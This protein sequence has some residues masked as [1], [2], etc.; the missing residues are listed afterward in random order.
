MSLSFKYTAFRRFCPKFAVISINTSV[1]SIIICSKSPK[2]AGKLKQNIE[3][4]VGIPFECIFIDNSTCNYSIFSAYNEGIRRSQYPYL[5]FLHEDVA[6]QT[7]DWGKNLCSHLMN[8]RVG[9]IGLCGSAYQ[10]KV[11]AS[12]S[13]YEYTAHIVQ[14]DK[15]G[16]LRIFEPSDGYDDRH[17]KHIVALDGVFL[18]ARR[19]LF[20]HIAFD[21]NTFDGFHAYEL[22]LCLQSHILG[23]KN[24][25]VNDI[26]LIHFSKGRHNEDWV[27]NILLF[28]DKWEHYLPI[29]IG[30]HSHERIAQR[31]TTYMRKTFLKNLIRSGYSNQDCKHLLM[32]HLS[33]D[34]S[35][36][37][38]VRSPKFDRWLFS[39]R[40]KK[41][42]ST[43]FKRPASR[44]AQD[45]SAI[46]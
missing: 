42:P 28:V 27:H 14:S 24:L 39:M 9:L 46:S 7:A 16:K 40:L 11:P 13:L 31:E 25:A 22:D 23:Y 43:L 36:V 17:E 21:E 29:E 32:K 5:C 2:L 19:E 33:H 12:W 41:K 45:V 37:E 3:L 26:L 4:T 6:F 1:L 34:L 18:A 10:S 20:K 30:D 8:P 15:R 35:F 44:I 38:W